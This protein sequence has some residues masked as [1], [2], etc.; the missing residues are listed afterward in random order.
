MDVIHE[1]A[2]AVLIADGI[3]LVCYLGYM[4]ERNYRERIKKTTK[5]Q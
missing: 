4:V 3:A 2:L 5:Y 1:I